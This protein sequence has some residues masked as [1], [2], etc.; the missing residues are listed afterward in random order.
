MNQTASVSGNMMT[1]ILLTTAAFIVT[2]L[3]GCISQP[4]DT[5]M[6]ANKGSLINK[7]RTASIIDSP[8]DLVKNYGAKI[9]VTNL[10]LIF[11]K[12]LK[13]A[14]FHFL[15]WKVKLYNLNF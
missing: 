3:M 11:L 12:L 9:L 4:S 8:R 5:T 6:S 10:L 15:Y 2:Q 7:S 1:T 13:T 14:R